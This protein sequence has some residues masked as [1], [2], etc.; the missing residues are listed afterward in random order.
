MYTWGQLKTEARQRLFPAGEA[1][2]LVVAHDKM[3]VDAIMDL[4]RYVTCLQQDNI[5]IVQAC[6][7][8][9]DCGMT[10]CDWPRGRN[11]R[12]SVIDKIDPATHYEDASAPDDWCAE[13]IYREVDF[14]HVHR[15]RDTSIRSGGLLPMGIFFCLGFSGFRPVPTD[16]GLPAG[17]PPLDLGLHYSQTSTDRPNGRAGRG[18]WA[19][20]RGK[21]YIAPWLQSTESVI[22]K[23]DGIK[24]IWSDADPVDQDPDLSKAVEEYVRW[25]HSEIYDHDSEAASAAAAAYNSARRDLIRE[26]REETRTRDCEGSNARQASTLGSSTTS[27][28]YNDTVGS[29]SASCQGN[30]TGP[31]VNAVIPVG[32]VG[33]NTS[34]ADANNTA[35]IQAV[36]QAQAKLNCTTPPVTY[37]N[38]ERQVTVSCTGETGAPIP[39]G[40]PATATVPANTVSST[41]SQDDANNQAD[42]LGLQ[43]ATAKLSCTWYNKAIT[44]TKPCAANP[45]GPTYSATV[46]A[47]TYSSTDSQKAADVLATTDATN[48]VNQL[49]A[50]N[51]AGTNIFWNTDQPASATGVCRNLPLVVN[52]TVPAHTVSSPISQN[53]ANQL[54]QALANQTAQQILNA[55][56]NSPNCQG[57]I[58]AFPS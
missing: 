40:N 25:K 20:D 49:L 52:Y 42:I 32:T 48:Q 18:I 27:I 7:T 57:N 4:Q 47:G 28:Y 33:S 41:I 36:A 44:V 55:E 13:V 53:D 39:A 3:F 22:L 30:T 17:L 45:T 38:V 31:T 12:V 8:L 9:Y 14:C 10:V 5:T 23:W 11:L 26:C 6:E 29:A 51:C 43:Q 24:R 1:D 58:F 54:A 35:Q 46:P 21:I 16:A 34:V 19:K 56:L 50:T 15:Y 2:N 37:W